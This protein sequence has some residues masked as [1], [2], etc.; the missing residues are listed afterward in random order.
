MQWENNTDAISASNLHY[1]SKTLTNR[2]GYFV[3][4]LFAV[5]NL[6]LTKSKNKNTSSEICSLECCVAKRLFFVHRHVCQYGQAWPAR[7]LIRSL[8]AISV[9]LD[10]F[11]NTWFKIIRTMQRFFL[12]AVSRSGLWY[13][14]QCE[15]VGVLVRLSGWSDIQFRFDTD[16]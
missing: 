12:W 8:P 7:I 11:G 13:G 14:G 5:C 6:A 15:S 4:A 3:V 2:H 9:H 16:D 1:P 10:A